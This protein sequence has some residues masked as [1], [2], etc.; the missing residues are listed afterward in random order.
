MLKTKDGDIEVVIDD[1]DSESDF[2]RS[3]HICK[4]IVDLNKGKIDFYA[5]DQKM[6]TTFEFSMQITMK[7][8]AM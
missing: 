6:G 8:G 7:K 5:N 2:F 3:L 1:K 4:K